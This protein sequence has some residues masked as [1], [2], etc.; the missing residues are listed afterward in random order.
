MQGEIYACA[1]T[2]VYTFGPTFRAENSH[3][4][5][6]INKKRQHFVFSEKSRVYCL[7]RATCII[8]KEPD[9]VSDVGLHLWSHSP[10]RKIPHRQA[11]Q[12]TE[13]KYVFSEKSPMYS[14]LKR[15]RFI[16]CTEPGAL[17]SFA[18]FFFLV[19]CIFYKSLS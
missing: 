18:W 14:L 9:V 17:C 4:T 12:H 19:C 8:L 16:P 1:L 7:K 6:Q 5:R 15:A 10:R 11:N 13:I 2:S 3:T